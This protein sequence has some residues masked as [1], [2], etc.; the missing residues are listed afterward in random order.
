MD[1]QFHPIPAAF[2]QVLS[3]E[4]SA[5]LPFTPPY[6]SF[7]QLPLSQFL[8]GV[9]LSPFLS[10]PLF[11]PTPI[12]YFQHPFAAQSPFRRSLENP[13]AQ[14]WC[15]VPLLIEEPASRPIKSILLPSFITNL[16]SIG[17]RKENY[18][19]LGHCLTGTRPP[20]SL[21]QSQENS[22]TPPRTDA[23]LENWQ[24][25]LSEACKR[26][27]ERENLKMVEIAVE[28][29]N[30]VGGTPPSDSWWGSLKLSGLDEAPCSRAQ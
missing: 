26:E 23:P 30:S 24:A 7:V 21:A 19:L 11:S 6:H 20:Q 14:H 13:R 8:S 12:N 3:G 28:N 18:V 1:H 4:I 27:R 15:L 16:A 9:L 5:N 17:M 29:P 22:S 10:T 25:A 2:L